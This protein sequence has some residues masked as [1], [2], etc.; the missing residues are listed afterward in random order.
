MKTR[1]CKH[2][3]KACCDICERCFACC[4]CHKVAREIFKLASRIQKRDK[5]FIGGFLGLV[6][7]E[8]EERYGA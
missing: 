1:I 2:K 6:E 4:S 7:E 3:T 8:W 5:W